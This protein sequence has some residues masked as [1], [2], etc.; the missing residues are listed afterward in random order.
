MKGAPENTESGKNSEEKQRIRISIEVELIR[1]FYEEYFYDDDKERE[2]CPL[3]IS[4]KLWNLTASYNERRK[5]F[6]RKKDQVKWTAWWTITYDDAKFDNE[7]QFR[8]KLLNKF[9]NLAYLKKWKIMGVFEHGEDNNRL[10]FHGFFYIPKG[11]EIGKIVDAKIPSS[12]NG[13][14]YNYKENTEFR[15]LFG[16]NSYE[17]IEYESSEGKTNLAK[18]TSKMV[19]Y[20]QKGEKVYYSRYIPSGFVVQVK[21]SE[22]FCEIT[23][24]IKRTMKRV[25]LWQ[26]VMIRRDFNIERAK[27]LEL[28]NS[29]LNPYEIGLLDETA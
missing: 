14:W 19:G 15:K 11:S 24:K 12:K 6:F 10:H 28:P 22:I 26:D 3:F 4:R 8:S 7:E 20:M 21:G 25:V 1:R 29:D 5:R 23:R 9:R 16:I 2:P 13:G 27:P 17:S 18:Y